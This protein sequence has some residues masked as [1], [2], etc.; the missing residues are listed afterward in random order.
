LVF[1]SPR[2]EWEELQ[3]KIKITMENA[4]NLTVPLLVEINWGENWMEAK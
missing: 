1:E 2:D 3:D 4:V